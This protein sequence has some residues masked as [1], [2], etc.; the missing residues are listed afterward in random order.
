MTVSDRQIIRDLACRVAAIAA[1]PVQEERREVWYAQNSLQPHRPPIFISPEGSWSELLTPADLQCESEE[2]RGIE[3]GLRLRLYAWDHFADDQVCDATWSVSLAVANTGW[4]LDVTT[5][6]SDAPRGAYVWDAAIQTRADLDRLQT[7]TATHDPAESQRRLAYYQD[8]FGDILQVEL[9]GRWWWAFGLIDE[10]TRL[11]GITQTFWDMSDDP[12]FVHAG[13]Q[14]LMEGKLAWF[15]SLEQQG[16]LTLNNGNHYISS[17]AFGYCRELPQADYTGTARLMDL[18]GFAEAQTMSEVSPAMHEEFVLRYQLP[19]L[20]RFGLNNYGCCEPLHRKLDLLK[21]QVPRL[22]RVSI[23]PWADKRM[24]AEKLAGD[25]IFSWKPNPATL[26][27]VDF[28]PEWVRQDIRETLEIA[29]EHGCCVELILK[30]THT[31]N[32]QPQRFDEWGRIA[33]EEVERSLE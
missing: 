29:K 7:P 31:C 11:R 24:S 2:A 16:L 32:H 17:G 15:E 13:M 22:R 9:V 12:E 23:S 30:D 6:H 26:A 4:G 25:I 5:H 28:D 1:E 20:E 21:A 14:R 33:R 19:L 8:L 27:A 10:W 18:W 3:H